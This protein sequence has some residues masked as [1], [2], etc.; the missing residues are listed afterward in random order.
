[1][2]SLKS[3]YLTLITYTSHLG[4]V[5]SSAQ[6]LRAGAPILGSWV[7]ESETRRCADGNHSGGFHLSGLPYSFQ[8]RLLR[9]VGALKVSVTLGE[10]AGSGRAMSAV[11]LSS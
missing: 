4:P 6:Q 10:L 1:M 7:T 11:E 5:I 9:C 3:E 8:A 2:K